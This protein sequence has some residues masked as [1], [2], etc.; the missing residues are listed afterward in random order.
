MRKKGSTTLKMGGR[1]EIEQDGAEEEMID[2]ERS[3]ER[4]SERENK[5]ERI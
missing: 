2:K 3:Q 1:G 5:Q 4:N